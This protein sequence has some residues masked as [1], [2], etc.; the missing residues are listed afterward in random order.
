MA[1]FGRLIALAIAGAT[2]PL[3]GAHAENWVQVVTGSLGSVSGIEVCVDE[4][5]ITNDS[6]GLTHFAYKVCAVKSGHGNEEALDCSQNL[7]GAVKVRVYALNS[8]DRWTE[9]QRDKDSPDAALARY[10][11]AHRAK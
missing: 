10:V 5:R 7:N 6:E 3:A 4:D 8:T 9:H 2:V 11:C 1:G